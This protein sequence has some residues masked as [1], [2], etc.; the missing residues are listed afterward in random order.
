MYRTFQTLLDEILPGV[1][2]VPIRS[3][4]A[5]V[6]CVRVNGVANIIWD[7]SY[8]AKAVDIAEILL[9]RTTDAAATTE[10][11]ILSV[12]ADLLFD[13][14]LY[15]DAWRAGTIAGVYL[16]SEIAQ[17]PQAT[18]FQNNRLTKNMALSFLFTHEVAHVIQDYDSAEFH[19]FSSSIKDAITTY[20]AY[21]TRLSPIERDALLA[22]EG[23][24]FPGSSDVPVSRIDQFISDEL[25][26]EEATAD[27]YAMNV[28]FFGGKRFD[29]ST[30]VDVAEF[31][32][33]LRMAMEIIRDIRVRTRRVAVEE[34]EPPPIV[35]AEL[36]RGF[37]LR[38]LLFDIVDSFAQT[39]TEL[40]NV[41]DE[42]R[43]RYDRLLHRRRL[44]FGGLP[45]R[46][47][48]FGLGQIKAFRL[49]MIR[50]AALFGSQADVTQRFRDSYLRLRGWQC[51]SD[52]RSLD[53]LLDILPFI[54]AL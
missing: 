20:S 36:M 18:H 43:A 21:L 7:E 30:A 41:A 45:E 24:I 8:V 35:A 34:R 25:F 52:P 15:A 42:F 22:G 13:E 53:G 39:Q 9:G 12:M 28:V 46:L 48:D 44:I 2:V 29:C 3:I 40:S 6:F 31:I 33:A 26:I 27:F 47:V 19:K 14:G 49:R 1:R 54:T 51:A 11:L 17:E 4:T 32:L 50:V 23:F 10:A 16:P 38:H 5:D 37:L